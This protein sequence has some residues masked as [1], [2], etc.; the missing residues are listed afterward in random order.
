MSNHATRREAL[1]PGALVRCE[2]PRQ[3]SVMLD[4]WPAYRADRA[5]APDVIRGLDKLSYS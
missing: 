3:T 2:P 5:T 1:S 4:L